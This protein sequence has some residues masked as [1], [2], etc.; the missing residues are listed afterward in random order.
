MDTPSSDNPS[1]VKKLKKIA[2]FDPFDAKMVPPPSEPSVTPP[3]PAPKTGLAAHLPNHFWKKI[4]G[5]LILVIAGILVYFINRPPE[6]NQI[7]QRT[8]TPASSLSSVPTAGG[9]TKSAPFTNKNT[10][11]IELNSSFFSATQLPE[12]GEPGRKDITATLFSPL[13]PGE[14]MCW[15]KSPHESMW[16]EKQQ[17][18]QW[19]RLCDAAAPTSTDRIMTCTEY[20]PEGVDVFATFYPSG[21]CGPEAAGVATGYYRIHVRTY[22]KCAVSN[23]QSDGSGCKG[24]ADTVSPPFEIAP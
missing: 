20:D 18:G 8:P 1:V 21:K 22:T 12:K 17:E 24:I 14:M 19:V 3:P 16:L 13:A 9:P 6:E 4:M 5:I 7:A 15:H 23:R 11:L 10:W 2:S